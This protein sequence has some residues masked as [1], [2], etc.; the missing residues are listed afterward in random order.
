M[1][2]VPEK[3]ITEVSE[4]SENEEENDDMEEDSSEEEEVKNKSHSKK[5]SAKKESMAKGKTVAIPNKY[6]PPT[7]KSPLKSS[8]KR[9]KIDVSSDTS[10][11][12]FSRKKK[13]DNGKEKVSTAKQLGSKEKSGNV[14]FFFHPLFLRSV[15]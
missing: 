6:T 7:K 12:T 2:G 10:P 3:F 13:T 8:S 9:P 5:P 11:K 1:N 14:V 4:P 15:V